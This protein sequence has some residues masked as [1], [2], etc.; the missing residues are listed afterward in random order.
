VGVVGA[1][2]LGRLLDDR[3]GAF[4]FAVVTSVL[5][6]SLVVSLCVEVVGRRVRR[7]LRT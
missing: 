7:T 1:A 4:D 3:L 6:A 2:G 5:L